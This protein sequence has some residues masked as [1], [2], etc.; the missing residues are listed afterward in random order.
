MKPIPSH[1]SSPQPPR[2]LRALDK[3]ALD[4]VR[5]GVSHSIISPRDAASGLPT[6]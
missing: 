3:G 6:G 1:R 4:A 2:P 5:G